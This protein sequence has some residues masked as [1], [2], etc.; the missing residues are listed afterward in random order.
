MAEKMKHLVY[1]TTNLL[2]DKIYIGI[3]STENIEDGYL[4]SGRIFLKALKRYGKENF[5]RD[6]L[7]VF[8]NRL[9][10]LNKEAEIV[11]LDFINQES[12][13]NCT[14]GGIGGIGKSNKGY[15]HTEISLEKIRQ[16]GKRKCDEQTK[17]KIGKANSG[18][19]HSE[20]FISRHSNFMKEFY[21]KNTSHRK[22]S[23]H[24]DETKIK[25][26]ERKKGSIHSEESKLK[27][28]QAK[29]GKEIKGKIVINKLTNEIY[30]SNREAIKVLKISERTFYRKINTDNYFLQNG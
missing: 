6:I 22:G 14:L 1:R 12:N 2:N 29:K 4:G 24:T 8:D 28:S 3:H 15:K 20:E 26:S 13:Y 5:K 25:M 17:I 19:K 18:K 10:A 7:F 9:D 16:A 21:S 23:R 27:M 11:S 30:K